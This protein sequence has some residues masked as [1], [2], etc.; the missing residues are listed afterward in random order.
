MEGVVAAAVTPTVSSPEVP[1]QQ[2]E[3]PDNEIRA[4]ILS[5]RGNIRS[6]AAFS[7]AANLLMLAPSLYM[8]QVY[9]RAVASG[10]LFTLGMLTVMLVGLLALMGALEYVRNRVVIHAG[11]RIDDLL[12]RRIHQA[13]FER[14]LAG[15]QANAAQAVRDLDAIRQFLTGNAVFA[16]FD[17]P[18]TPLFLL[19]MFL[20]HPWVGLLALIGILILASLAWVNQRLSQDRKSTRL[21]SSH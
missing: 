17:A 11:S 4:A 13:A 3:N 6:V 18:W 21:N 14:G 1:M 20:F 10:N 8:L 7:A 16:F 5:L 2:Q 12:A 15:G 9:D 19:V